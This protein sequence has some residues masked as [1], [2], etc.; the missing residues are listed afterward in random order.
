MRYG[1][2][3]PGAKWQRMA[4]LNKP[5]FI[6]RVQNVCGRAVVAVA[7]LGDVRL[8]V[9]QPFTVQ[10]PGVNTNDF[11]V[12]TFAVSLDF[13]L[14]MLKLADDSL[15][16]VINQGASFSTSTGKLVRL[17]DTNQDGIADG[18]GTTLYSGLPAGQT[19]VRAAGRLVLVAGDAKPITVLRAGALPSDPLTPVGRIGI[20]YINNRSHPNSALAVRKTP[21]F[22]NRF[23]LLFHLGAEY[24]FAKTTN[25]LALTNSNIPGATGVLAGDSIHMLTL[26]D[27]GVNVTATNL[28]QI[29]SGLRN[30]A[31]YAFHPTTGDLYLQ[32]NGID[33]LV[34]GNEPHSADELNFIARTNLG[35]PVEF[36]GFPTNYSAY[37][38]NVVIGGAGIQPLITFRPI[39]DPA[40]GR[41]NEGVSD[42]TFAPPGF[43]NGLNA[44]MFLGFHGKFT[45]AGTANEE[46]P[47]AYADLTAGNYFHFIQGQQPGIGHFDGLLATRDSLFVADLVSTGSPFNGAG[48][49]VIYQ[50]K[51]LVTPSPPQL[52][53]RTVDRQVQLTWDRGAL[54][55]AEQLSGPWTDVTDAFSPHSV[56][57]TNPRNFFRTRY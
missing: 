42:I 47:L 57:A 44:G 14:G 15:L 13:P 31:G 29:A 11:R 32:D 21:G 6:R 19:V 17:T 26:I 18:A 37:R 56:S 35:G 27:D 16:V 54:Q 36:F 28:I 10:G 9:A 51:S 30:P 50:I 43:P 55:E 46:N 5:V 40:N 24:N 7:L 23:D 22:T 39:P 25:T 52:M 8:T 34:N 4:L 2:L 41:E 48:A 20:A 38:S 45:S 33:G 49:G 12:T 3:T 1:C 53:A